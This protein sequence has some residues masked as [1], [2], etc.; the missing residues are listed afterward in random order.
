[1]NGCA[2]CGGGSPIRPEGHARWCADLVL[3]QRPV[4]YPYAHHDHVAMWQV[5]PADAPSRRAVPA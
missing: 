3:D 5:V 4:R 2:N 1:M